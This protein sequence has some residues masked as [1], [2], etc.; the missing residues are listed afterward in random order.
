MAI[1]DVIRR[2]L[3]FPEALNADRLFGLNGQAVDP[4]AL[5]MFEQ[6]ACAIPPTDTVASRSVLI[7]GG[8]EM[9]R[10]L[11]MTIPELVDPAVNPAFQLDPVTLA[12]LT[13]P[14]PERVRPD[15]VLSRQGPI[16]FALPVPPSV[17]AAKGIGTVEVWPF[18]DQGTTLSDGTVLPAAPLTWPSATLRAREGELVHTELSTRLNTHTIHMHA[19]EPTAMNDGVGHITFEV[20]GP[21]YRYQWRAAD[22][23]TYFYHCHKNTAL[24]FEMGMY[25]FLIVDPDV[26]GAPFADGGPGTIRYRDGLLDYDREVLWAVDEIDVEWRTVML[27]NY[28]HSAG[29]VC[30][31]YNTDGLGN[32]TGATNI[33]MHAFDPDIFLISGI[34]NEWTQ[35]GIPGN[36]FGEDGAA[37]RVRRGEV[38]LIRLL[39]AGYNTQRYTFGLPVEVIGIDGRTLGFGPF[40]Q[41]SEPFT[42]PANTPFELT[43]A[44]R[45]D[46]LIDTGNVATGEYD[47][48]IDFYDWHVRTSDPNPPRTGFL[49]TKIII[50]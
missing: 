13:L 26:T 33:G 42:V 18:Q 36:P 2:D 41:Y 27:A 14:T 8:E 11:N 5:V 31:F 44:R 1:T 21:I 32:P 47:V 25:G 46:L 22:A 24:H 38:V 15:R 16:S 3:G 28:G 20:G 40:M 35:P 48:H 50:E 39:H 23:G 9:D 37:V 29:I 4:N 19:I 6:H 10:N 12:P 34:A 30:P 43:T 17:Q 45:W 7:P 49:D